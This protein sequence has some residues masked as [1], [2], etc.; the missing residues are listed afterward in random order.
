[1]LNA[2]RIM[3]HTGFSLVKERLFKVIPKNDQKSK[4]VVVNFICDDFSKQCG[5]VY[6]STRR[7]TKDLAFLPRQMASVQYTTL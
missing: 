6:C 7:D 4:D 3:K 5:I 2:K 1:M